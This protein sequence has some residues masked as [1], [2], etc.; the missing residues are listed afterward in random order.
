MIM[1][2]FTSLSKAIA[3][4]L[5][6]ASC[7][8]ATSFAVTAAAA[9]TGGTSSGGQ[10]C[11]SISQL[12]NGQTC[13]TG[14]TSIAGITKAVVSFI[15]VIAGIIAVIMIVVAG[16]RFITANG[17]SNGIS[18]ARTALFYAAIGLAVAALAQVLV[19]LVIN[20]LAS[21]GT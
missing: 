4:L 9:P 20:R 21:P 13:A 5:I 18:R 10:A 16:L 6:I 3:S 7:M 2:H 14:T 15:S 17:D 11:E 19:H 12:G 1:Q 8:F